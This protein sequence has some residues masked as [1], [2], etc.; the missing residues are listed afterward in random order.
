ML[1]WPYLW[2]PPLDHA[3]FVI[4]CSSHTPLLTDWRIG[5]NTIR[6]TEI[7]IENFLENKRKYT[8]RVVLVADQFL[9]LPPLDL[10]HYW[11][12]GATRCCL[13]SGRWRYFMPL[14]P[15]YPNWYKS[16]LTSEYCRTCVASLAKTSIL[17]IL[18]NV[19]NEGRQG[20][21]V[22]YQWKNG[23]GV[24]TLYFGHQEP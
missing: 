20:I 16:D 1:W 21:L 18:Y 22:F 2:N 3:E 7:I 15:P 19:S 4:Y 8:S 14:Q 10:A 5:R 9:S 13:Y 11:I 23:M 6:L 24:A 17:K 12:C